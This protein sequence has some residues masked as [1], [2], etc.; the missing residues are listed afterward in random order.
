MQPFG[1]DF[2]L[3]FDVN[4]YCVLAY[5][6]TPL[7]EINDPAFAAAGIRVVLKR[8]DLNHPHVSGNKWWKLKYNIEKVLQHP[9]R[10]LLTFGGAYSNHL[11]ATAAACHEL[12]LRSIGVVRGE[13]HPLLNDTLQ[14]VKDQGMQLHYV[15][16]ESYR[17][18]TEADFIDALENEFGAFV[19]VPEGGSNEEAVQGASEFAASLDQSFDYL[20]CPVGTGGT[21]AGL[22]RGY[23]STKTILGFSV[24]KGAYGM[25]EE[26]RHWNPGKTNW[27]L[28][29]DYHF[30]GYAK[31]TPDLLQFI[32]QFK[33]RHAVPLE[34]IY[35]GKMMSGIFDLT[36][37]GFFKRGSTL[38]AIH[39]GGLQGK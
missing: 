35:T 5:Q 39:T 7:V 1:E 18:K 26:I 16:R 10:T 23:N 2:F 27:Q 6:S 15:S 4:L 9:S 21:L 17:H 22:I 28:I 25:V 32:A 38:L 12:G 24:L 19:L 13:E 29:T 20:C 14:F 36:K 37:Q 31:S 11:Y 30:G 34:P 3:I 8:E 33:A